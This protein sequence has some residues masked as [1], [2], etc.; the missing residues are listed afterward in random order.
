MVTG[1]RKDIVM[2]EGSADESNISSR[3]C[4]S[5]IR[6]ISSSGLFTMALT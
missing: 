6:S 3:S 2:V 4:L 1:T 5:E